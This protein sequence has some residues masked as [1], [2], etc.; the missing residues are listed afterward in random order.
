MSEPI[1]APARIDTEQAQ[2][3][4]VVPTAYAI[5]SVSRIHA[6]RMTLSQVHFEEGKHTANKPG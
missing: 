2:S 4:D 5:V 3:Q 6:V 1:L